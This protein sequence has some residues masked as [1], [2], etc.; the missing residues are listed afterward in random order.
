MLIIKIIIRLIVYPAVLALFCL[1]GMVGLI[2]WAIGLNLDL[3]K[4]D[5]ENIKRILTL[6]GIK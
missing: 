5:I 6:R 3:T 2:F 1:F 4:Q